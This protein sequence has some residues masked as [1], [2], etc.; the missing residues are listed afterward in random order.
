[1]EYIITHHGISQNQ[2]ILECLKIQATKKPMATPFSNIALKT[3]PAIISASEKFTKRKRKRVS[4]LVI[5]PLR[6][7][8]SSQLGRWHGKISR[9]WLWSPR[10][11]GKI[12][13][14][15]C[16]WEKNKTKKTKYWEKPRLITRYL[17][18]GEPSMALKNVGKKN[19]S[20]NSRIRTH[21]S[22]SFL[23]ELF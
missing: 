17:P 18:L 14:K 12:R 2:W 16:E 23:G 20:T 4:F 15:I 11:H 1:M 13:K 6:S 5:M 7:K 3:D 21:V 10:K 9:A 22:S 19:V 8:S